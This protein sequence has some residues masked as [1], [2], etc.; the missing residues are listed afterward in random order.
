MKHGQELLE[1]LKADLQDATARAN[2]RHEQIL[3]GD[4]ELNDCFRSVQA[5]DAVIS[6]LRDKIEI[7]KDGGMAEFPELCYLDGTPTGA[8]LVETRHGAKYLVNHSD[9]R[10]EWVDP[11]VQEKTLAKKG[12]KIAAV[13]K[14]AWAAFHGNGTRVFPARVNYWTG[15]EVS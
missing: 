13:S 6:V 8:S 7:L 12:Y 1:Q 3:R 10:K 11:Y 9:G 5:A 4:M 2:A 14:P 15:E